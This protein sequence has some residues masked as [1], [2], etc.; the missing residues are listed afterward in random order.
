[1]VNGRPGLPLPTI[2]LHG[3]WAASNSRS[4][5][6]HGP[7]AS[8]PVVEARYV[9]RLRPL[10]TPQ[11][12][13]DFLPLRRRTRIGFQESRST[14][15]DR[16][17][18]TDPGE[19]CE[20]GDATWGPGSPRWVQPL[21]RHTF[22]LLRL[23]W[24]CSRSKSQSHCSTVSRRHTSRRPTR[25]AWGSEPG[26]R[27]RRAYRD[28]FVIPSSPARSFTSRTSIAPPPL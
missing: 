12:D 3:D 9:S 13:R 10:P 2:L 20:G 28:C 5:P 24:F 25:I 11:A 19:V 16:P 26:S 17:I 15:I 8:R 4:Y 22:A 23:G 21:E 6:G 27:E 1:M 14:A 18:R 7:G